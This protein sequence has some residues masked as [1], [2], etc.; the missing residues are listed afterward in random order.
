MGNLGAFK[1]FSAKC[2]VGL[3]KID[4]GSLLTGLSQM[5]QILLRFVAMG[6]GVCRFQGAMI[7]S[8]T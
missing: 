1:M 4:V 2:F 6:L 7:W 5:S 3:H 8:S